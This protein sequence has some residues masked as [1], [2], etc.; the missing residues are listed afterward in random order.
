MEESALVV[1]RLPGGLA[2]ARLAGAQVDE[3]FRGLRRDLVEELDDHAA[4]QL[5]V[6][7]HVEEASS[8]VHTRLGATHLKSWSFRIMK[9]TRGEGTRKGP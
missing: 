1:K 3:V 4:L 2:D 5:A 7:R 9:Q 8:S 6:D